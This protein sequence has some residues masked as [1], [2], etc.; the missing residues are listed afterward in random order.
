MNGEGLEEKRK[1]REGE[2]DRLARGE[3][4]GGKKERERET[5]G[6]GSYPMALGV[7]W[8]RMASFAAY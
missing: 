8:I 4:G 7:S 6:G 3:I 1:G 5:S 2:G